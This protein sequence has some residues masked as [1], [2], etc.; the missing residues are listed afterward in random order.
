[1]SNIVSKPDHGNKLIEEG[2]ATGPFQLYLDDIEQK[3]NIFLLAPFTVE[4][5]TVTVSPAL[6][7]KV[8]ASSRLFGMVMVTDESGGVVPAFSDGT[9]WRR[10]TDRAIIS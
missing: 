8:P 1:M 2:K 10:V 9:N 7:P 5:L 4:D 3:L 6:K